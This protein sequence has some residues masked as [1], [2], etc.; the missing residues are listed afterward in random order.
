DEYADAHKLTI[1]ERLRLFLQV[2]EAVA[3]AHTRRIVHRDIKPVNILVTPAGVPKLLDFGIAKVLHPTADEPTGSVTGFRL[4]TPEYGSPEQV[5][6]RPATTVSDVYSLG[7]VLYEILTGHSPYRPRSRAP[8][9]VVEAVQTTEPERP[10]L[11]VTRS[12]AA[13]NEPSRRLGLNP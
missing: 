7:V 10:S 9:D 4:L 8:A 11:A 5:E 1:P 3:Y 6:G 2:C 13:V 12:E